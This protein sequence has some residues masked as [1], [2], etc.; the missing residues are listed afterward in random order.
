LTV[1]ALKKIVVLHSVSQE[2]VVKSLSGA[3]L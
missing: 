1:Q 3:P 2:E